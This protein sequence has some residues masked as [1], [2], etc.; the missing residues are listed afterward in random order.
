LVHL[1]CFGE[2]DLE[3]LAQ[4]S[5]P[6]ILSFSGI[7]AKGT[8]MPPIAKLIDHH[9]Q[10]VLGSDWGI[11]RP[12]E[13]LQTYILVLKNNGIPV[14]DAYPLLNLHT[15]NGARVL[16]LDDDIGT[17]EAG[18]KAD[19]VFIDVSD[20]KMNTVLDE[21]NS[22]K[23]LE[24]LLSEISSDK[25]SDV[26]INGEFYLRNGHLLT[27]SEDDLAIE[28]RNLFKKLMNIGKDD[29]SV[30][31]SKAAVFS[32]SDYKGHIDD[33][34][35]DLHIDEGF[36]VISKNEKSAKPNKEKNVFNDNINEMPKKPRK[37]FG[38]DDL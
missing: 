28:G 35:D 10:L 31:P 13:N 4:A 22:E 38:D 1:A 34:R 36:K 9:I 20:F 6:L 12:L 27:Y 19:L 11:S 33:T 30:K 24:T 2:Q 17:I 5:V 32:L 25:V 23:M 8:D 29:P 37:I 26:M 21:E 16:E 14:L 18:K 3:I 15:K 7:L